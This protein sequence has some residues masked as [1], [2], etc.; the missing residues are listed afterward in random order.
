MTE[1]HC[2]ALGRSGIWLRYS[3]LNS[4]PIGISKLFRIWKAC[5]TASSPVFDSGAVFTKN[6]AR[7]KRD[8][9]VMS[10]GKPKKP[11]PI[12]KDF[13]ST[14][15]NLVGALVPYCKWM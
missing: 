10:P 8:G 4:V 6:A 1:V 15:P 9:G 13:A 11:E 7:T 2:V 12:P 3:G 5:D 14:P